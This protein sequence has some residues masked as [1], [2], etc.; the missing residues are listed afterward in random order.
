MRGA[1]V[2]YFALAVH[3]GILWKGEENVEAEREEG[4]VI[5][6]SLKLFGCLM[7]QVYNADCIDME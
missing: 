3:I 7:G 1:L 4:K 6:F 5:V 2:V